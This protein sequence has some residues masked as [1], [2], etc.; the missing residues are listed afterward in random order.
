MASLRCE[1]G[2]NEWGPNTAGI[3]DAIGR[4]HRLEP[5]ECDKPKP[6]VSK[7]L[8]PSYHVQCDDCN[9]HQDH[10]TEDIAVEMALQHSIADDHSLSLTKYQRKLI[11]AAAKGG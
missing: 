5:A 9:Y 7:Y 2:E 3:E 1:C 8:A 11:Q 10:F 6:I 4:V